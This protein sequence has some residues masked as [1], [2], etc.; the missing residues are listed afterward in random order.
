VPEQ[1]KIMPQFHA[2]P[3]LFALPLILLAGCSGGETRDAATQEKVTFRP[4][5]YEV[6]PSGSMLGI[7]MPRVDSPGTEKK[8]L[9]VSADQASDMPNAFIRQYVMLDPRCS[10]EDSVREGNAFSGKASCPVDPDKGQGKFTV[11]YQGEMA[12]ESL[13]IE[14]KIAMDF[15]PSDQQKAKDPEAAQ[16]MEK[17]SGMMKNIGIKFSAVR[18]GD[19]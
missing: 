15:T 9:C 17:M 6:T 1:E 7:A 18:M 12:A 14:V 2:K 3:T 5:R 8:S 10:L 19:C 4:G 13:D 11:S 16:A